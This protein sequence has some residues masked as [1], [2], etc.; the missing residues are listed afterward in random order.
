ME[1]LNVEPYLLDI[2]GEGH[3]MLNGK[4]TAP[5]LMK[6]GSVIKLLRNRGLKREVEWLNDY[7]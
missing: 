4:K 7:Y 5:G 3:Q 2:T 6:L 1:G